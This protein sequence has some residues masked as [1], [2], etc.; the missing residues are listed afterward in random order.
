MT[1]REFQQRFGAEA[2]ALVQNATFII[3]LDVAREDCPYLPS[4]SGA[5]ATSIIRHDG[6]VEGWN[7]C[8]KF[9]KTLARSEP[10]APPVTQGPLYPDPEKIKS[11]KNQK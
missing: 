5:D 10:E 11:D 3:A 9:L 6:L 7:E 2:V 8:L 4:K 1:K